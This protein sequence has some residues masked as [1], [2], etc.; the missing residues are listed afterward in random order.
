MLGEHHIRLNQAQHHAQEELSGARYRHR[1][2]SIDSKE[3]QIIE[4]APQELDQDGT[5][6]I[7]RKPHT[8]I[9]ML[10]Y[11]LDDTLMFPCS[12]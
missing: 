4:S 5:M 6:C 7:V 9:K 1:Y 8:Y 11:N 2:H 12:M 3:A 10:M